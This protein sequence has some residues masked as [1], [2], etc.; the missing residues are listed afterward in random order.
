MARQQYLLFARWR[1][2][3]SEC[4]KSSQYADLTLRRI[5]KP[6]GAHTHARA[7]L[8]LHIQGVRCMSA[9]MCMLWAVGARAPVGRP[10]NIERAAVLDVRDD[11]PDGWPRAIPALTPH[12]I[13]W[14]PRAYNTQHHAVASCSHRL[15]SAAQP[16]A[17]NV[18]HAT[19]GAAHIA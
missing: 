8:P 16:T 13:T 2:A 18:Q 1:L 14:N 9:R 3:P 4:P 6:G 7:P 17:C 5:L 11:L 15:E 10:R 12:N 19:V